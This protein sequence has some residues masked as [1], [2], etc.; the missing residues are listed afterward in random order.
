MANHWKSCKCG[1]N[2]SL[3]PASVHFGR[4]YFPKMITVFPM[5]HA[6]LQCD[7]DTPPPK[8]STQLSSQIQAGLND[9]LITSRMWQSDNKCLL[10]LNPQKPCSFFLSLWKIQSADATVVWRAHAAGRTHRFSSQRPPLSPAFKWVSSVQAP[11]E[12]NSHLRRAFS[13]PRCFTSQLMKSHAASL[14]FPSENTDIVEQNK[15][16]RTVFS[17]NSWPKNLWEQNGCCSTLSFLHGV[18][19]SSR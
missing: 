15:P 6:L 1:L 13:N 2:F 14:V 9:S 5:P 16:S 19:D 11:G 4:L 7:P 18:K 10:S 17:L 12:W 8:S 3:F